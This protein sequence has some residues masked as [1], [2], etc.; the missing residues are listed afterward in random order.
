M[1]RQQRA[2]RDQQWCSGAEEGCCSHGDCGPSTPFSAGSS[3]PSI[4][5]IVDS[6]CSEPVRIE[7]R[8]T[9]PWSWSVLRERPEDSRA[10]LAGTA[11]TT[12]SSWPELGREGS[13][14]RGSNPESSTNA[15]VAAA[16]AQP[17][18]I[19]YRRGFMTPLVFVG[20]R[21]CP[22]SFDVRARS[23]SPEVHCVTAWQLRA[24]AG[25]ANRRRA[26]T[27]LWCTCFATVPR[28]GGRVHGSWPGKSCRSTRAARLAAGAVPPH[29]GR[30]THLRRSERRWTMRVRARALLR[31]RCR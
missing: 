26:T 14:P 17:A 13:E 21:P 18:R 27:L 1:D 8:L 6:P 20:R 28:G 30:W 2:Q 29:A 12:G 24:A 16:R 10:T 23:C 31:P 3:V 22:R 25:I 11:S 5:R 9:S 7:S 19:W 4:G 15:S